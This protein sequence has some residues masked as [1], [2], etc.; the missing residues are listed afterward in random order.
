MTNVSRNCSNVHQVLV[1]H[2]FRVRV[3]T[4]TFLSKTSAFNMTLCILDTIFGDHH[5]CNRHIFNC[6]C[7][8]W[9]SFFSSLSLAL[10]RVLISTRIV[11]PLILFRTTHW[12]CSLCS[13]FIDIDTHQHAFLLA[14]GCFHTLCVRVRCAREHVYHLNPPLCPISSN[15]YS[16]NNNNIQPQQFLWHFKTD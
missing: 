3:K 1:C 16:N 5:F 8:S 15:A 11:F 13:V 6:K 4:S 7:W 14:R 10:Q 12:M 2:F 9:F